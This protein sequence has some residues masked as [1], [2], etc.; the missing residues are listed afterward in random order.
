MT[1]LQN[2]LT[3]EEKCVGITKFNIMTLSIMTI[4]ITLRLCNAQHNDTKVHNQ[5]DQI[6]L[7]LK[8]HYDFFKYEIAQSNFGLF[9]VSANLL[10]VHLYK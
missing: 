6:G 8:A 9:L 2:N 1:G 5:G 4:S 10:Y 3:E 7:L